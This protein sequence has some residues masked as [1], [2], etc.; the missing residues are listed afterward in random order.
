MDKNSD[1]ISIIV[2]LYHGR[3]YVPGI[4]RQI[5][6]CAGYTPD[7]RM[8][9]VL[10]NDTPEEPLT[11]RI[12]AGAVSVKVLNTEKNRGIHGARVRG[13]KNSTGNYILFLDQDDR[14][15]PKYF[16]S[17]LSHLGEADAVVCRLL[18]GGRQ[19]YDT[20][21][22]FEQVITRDYMISVR[23]SIISPGQVLMKRE[24]IPEIWR[25]VRLKNNGAD[26]WLLWLCMLGEKRRFALNTEI[27]FEHMVS[28]EN[29][30]ANVE[31]MI[32]SEQEMYK[33]LKSGKALSGDE[34]RTLQNT[35]RTMA[36][37][38]IRLLSRF[39]K[40]F[41]VYN[42]WLTMQEQGLYIHDYLKEQGVES[43]AIYGDSYIGKRLYRSLRGKGPEV[44]CFIDRNA[45]FLE[46]DI[47][48]YLPC[49]PLPAVDFIVICLVDEVD[50]IRKEL[51]DL[52]GAK[53]SSITELLAE[54]KE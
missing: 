40:M 8:E 14:I 7:V 31:H 9:L 11:E 16:F 46:E 33:V 53:I 6:D 41:F 1:C 24:E 15:K 23:N 39:Q 50:G 30:S 36:V 51:A 4:I 10:S 43:M 34:I 38:H 37:E 12:F 54:M 28:G 17:Q 22:P 29:E 42:D 2:P 32:A 26:D 48:V 45:E 13:L 20:R 18:H 44:R 49:A 19:F 35:V 5:E 27:L 25:E 21:M 47:P 52:S 3:K